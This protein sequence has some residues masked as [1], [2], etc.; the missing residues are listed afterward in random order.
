MVLKRT[1]NILICIVIG[2]SVK[3][4]EFT[5]IKYFQNFII[6][7]KKL[8]G[9]DKVLLVCIHSFKKK[10]VK[11]L[12][13]KVSVISIISYVFNTLFKVKECERARKHEQAT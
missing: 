1:E 7:V 9:L 3:I 12:K 6:K 11:K 13:K 2:Y 4:L 8:G 5:V 10:S